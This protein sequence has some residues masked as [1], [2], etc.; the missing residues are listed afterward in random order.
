M[1]LPVSD[2][3]AAY[4]RLWIEAF[5][6]NLTGIAPDLWM[7]VM[8]AV[9]RRF[10]TIAHASEKISGTI[11]KSWGVPLVEVASALGIADGPLF[12][13]A[14]LEQ[15]VQASYVASRLVICGALDELKISPPRCDSSP[16]HS[17]LELAPVAPFGSW[18]TPQTQAELRRLVI[19]ANF[20]PA[21]FRTMTEDLDIH[22][23]D[24]RLHLNH[25]VLGKFFQTL[26]D[27]L[28]DRMSKEQSWDRSSW[29]KK[30]IR[31]REVAWSLSERQ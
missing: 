26:P 23:V 19:D 25:L 16:W 17:P 7:L 14:E 18:L 29:L 28:L 13:Q 21:L 1:N 22:E 30:E 5:E 31:R 3:Y 4:L 27:E 20:P 2:G 15:R 11:Q 12:V 24:E 6:G 10:G 8:D 9:V